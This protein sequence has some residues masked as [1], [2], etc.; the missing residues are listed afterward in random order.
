MI[1]NPFKTI[2]FSRFFLEMKFLKI[3][4]SGITRFE[5]IICFHLNQNLNQ[6]LYHL[7]FAYSLLKLFFHLK[8][9][10]EVENFSILKFDCQNCSL[11]CLELARCVCAKLF[12]GPG[13]FVLRLIID[14][15]CSNS[16]FFL[17]IL[18]YIWQNIDWQSIQNYLDF[19]GFS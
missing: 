2:I 4:I 11:W 7:V 15:D 9:I 16:K 3:I 8:G 6:K 1:G 17:I 19:I 14:C 12:W 18:D 13:A 5:I 10:R